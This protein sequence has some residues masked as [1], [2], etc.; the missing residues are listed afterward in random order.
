MPPLY[1]RQ[2]GFTLVELFVAVLIGLLLTLAVMVIQGQL[3]RT[4]M[5][6]SDA[7][8]RNDQ[9]RSAIDT[10]Q[11]DLSNALYMVNGT[12]PLCAATVQ[13]TG[14]TGTPVISVSAVEAL[15]QPRALP[16]STTVV[17]ALMKPDAYVTASL[18]S[19][20]VSHMLTINM[21]PTALRA[22]PAAGVQ[23]APYKVVHSWVQTAPGGQ[24]AV[25][26]GVLPLSNIDGMAAGDAVTLMVP[27]S[28]GPLSGL[29]CLRFSAASPTAVSPT[30]PAYI[31]MPSP[32]KFGDFTQPLRDAGLLGSTQ[33]LTDSQLVAAKLKN[34][35]PPAAVA[36]G[37]VGLQALFGVDGVSNATAA[38][39]GI[40]NY[41]TWSQVVSAQI[42][43]RVR[44]VLYAVV[45]RTLQTD[46]RNPV[47]NAVPIPS[48]NLG[49]GDPTFTPFYPRTTDEQR[50]R[51]KVHVAE[52]ALRIQNWGS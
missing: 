48:P 43:G 27:M 52:V 20:N 17:D 18:S 4:N 12:S 28:G 42:A 45:T 32:G 11:R 25:A 26:N 41:R 37:V 50:D 5:Q 29:A 1:R 3:T 24:Q 46:A 39:G 15:P 14:S 2:A 34:E 19:A 13:Y 30:F 38:T 21:V 51:Y 31:T 47:V 23:S 36:V 6:L 44:S 7:G 8:Q 16:S 49:T 22:P 33:V 35:G 9:A 10:L 40:T